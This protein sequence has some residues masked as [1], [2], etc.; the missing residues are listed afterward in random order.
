MITSDIDMLSPQPESELDEKQD[1]A[2]ITTDEVLSMEED[3]PL[4]DDHEAMKRK[5]LPADPDLETID[6]QMTVWH[7]DGYRSLEQKVHSPTFTCG[8]TPW[9]LLVFPF[10]NNNA[11]DWCSCYLEHNFEEKPPDSWYTCVQFLIVAYNPKDPSLYQTNTASHRYN[12]DATDWGFNKFFELR[13]AVHGW[14]E[15]G[16]RPLLEGD[17]ITYNIYV[18]TVKDPTG[19]LW[20]SFDKY[21]GRSWLSDSLLTY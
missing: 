13:K 1:V 7:V 10:G 4:A 15:P 2:T 8:E 9:R 11:S 6:E 21:V 14:L 19:V 17:S 5:Y 12:S 3:D 20:H 16:G 18:R